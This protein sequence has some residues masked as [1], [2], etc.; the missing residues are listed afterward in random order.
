QRRRAD[1][2]DRGIELPDLVGS[3][4]PHRSVRRYRQIVDPSSGIERELRGEDVITTDP[5]IEGIREPDAGRVRRNT[6]EWIAE[7]LASNRNAAE[8]VSRG[9]DPAQLS[10][11]VAD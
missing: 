2:A 4:E 9:R 7:D 8:E 11:V 1:D 3:G 10:I 6:G 5:V